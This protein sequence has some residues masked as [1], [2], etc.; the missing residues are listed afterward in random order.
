MLTFEAVGVARIANRL[1][2]SAGLL[3][4]AANSALSSVGF[5]LKQM[6]RDAVNRND[7]GWRNLSY[8]TRV[9]KGVRPWQAA[10]DGFKVPRRARNQKPW[11]QIGS[12]VVYQVD[13]GQQE[14]TFGFFEGT[15]GMKTVRGR[16]TANVL[17]ENVVGIARRITEGGRITMTEPMRKF[18]AGLGFFRRRGSSMEIPGRP[19]V[20]P[21]RE[22]SRSALPE[23]FSA[24]FKER[25]AKYLGQEQ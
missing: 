19:M 14:M 13:K 20:V 24:K 7:L 10:A 6:A 23:I 16:K 18:L 2:K 12:L 4:R 1:E 22:R 21:I 11:G 25:L 8:V 15:F 17:G 5:R 3:T 9:L